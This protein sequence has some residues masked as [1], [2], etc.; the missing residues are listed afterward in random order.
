MNVRH[1]RY[2]PQA[3]MLDLVP[4]WTAI[5]ALGVFM[6][7]LMDGFDLGVGMLFPFAPNDHARDLMMASV[8]PVWDGNETWL[9]LGGIALLAVFPLAFAIIMP[10]LYF[11]ILFMLMGLIFRGVAFEFRGIAGPR[12]ALWDKSFF[13]GSLIATFSQGIVLGAYVQGFEV[14]G[15]HFSGSSFDWLA[16]FPI[17]TGLGLVAGYCLLGATWLVMKTEGDLQNW[18]RRRS[19]Y[20]TFGVLAFIAMVSIWTPL[21]N[22]GIA[23]RWFSWP[24]IA[25]LSP[26]PI[27]TA[28]IAYLLFRSLKSKREL[29]P[30][31][32]AMGLF[33]MCYLGLGVSL[34]P[35]VVPHSISLW[36]AAAA[37]STQA[38]LAVGTMFLLPIIF[39]YTGWSYWV[40]RGK[41][42]GDMGYH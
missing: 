34:W 14:R 40:F 38:F 18:A 3:M 27:V 19:R 10:A 1:A 5:I 17:L 16:P 15:R 42:K 25:F 21:A 11:P 23:A 8:A 22:E 4:L 35:N 41:V 26:V 6:Y 31:V 20:F 29:A 39:F 13:W 28:A 7:V 37:P 33:V 9:V 32:G 24:N 30:F 2:R 12:R 36:D